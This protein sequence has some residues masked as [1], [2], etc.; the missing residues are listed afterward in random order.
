MAAQMFHLHNLS[1]G[2]ASF[3]AKSGLCWQL[4]SIP[5]FYTLLTPQRQKDDKGLFNRGV[6]L[7][8]KASTCLVMLRYFFFAGCTFVTRVP[9]PQLHGKTLFSNA[10]IFVG[11]SQHAYRR[12][13]L[14]RSPSPARGVRGACSPREFLKN[15]TR[16]YAFSCILRDIK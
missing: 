7:T 13:K 9:L 8:R 5:G 12:Q 2:P 11:T 3:G 1:T 4:V 6:V 14:G 15:Q 10:G 16:L